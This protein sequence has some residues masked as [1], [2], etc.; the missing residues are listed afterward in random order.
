M[1]VQRYELITDDD[2]DDV[3][4]EEVTLV[5]V[6]DPN[7]KEQP[8][9]AYDE[10]AGRRDDQKRCELGRKHEEQL[11]TFC[12][13]FLAFWIVSLVSFP[14]YL[15]SV[16]F[17]MS[18]ATRSGAISGC[19]GSVIVMTCFSSGL[20]DTTWLLIWLYGVGKRSIFMLQS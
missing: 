6:D 16:L 13:F 4:C 17:S 2:D 3:A 20:D 7:T 19:G 5:P 14:G 8:P 9:P 10:E 11:G 18:A 15:I 12:N 1:S